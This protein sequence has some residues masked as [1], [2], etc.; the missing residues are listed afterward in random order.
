MVTANN[1]QMPPISITQVVPK[2]SEYHCR[3]FCGIKELSQPR[4]DIAV[5][6]MSFELT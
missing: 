1:Q 6:G 2:E 5:L 4:E 3:D